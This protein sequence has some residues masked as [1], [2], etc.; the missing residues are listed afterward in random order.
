[1]K[2][3]FG[4]DWDCAGFAF[5][6]IKEV[7]DD[8][9]RWSDCDKFVGSTKELVVEIVQKPTDDADTTYLYVH[10]SLET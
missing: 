5:V 4:W 10:S 3:K 6:Q 9:R 2:V 7:D 8:G 1:M